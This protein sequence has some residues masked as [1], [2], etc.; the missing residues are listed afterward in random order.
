MLKTKSNKKQMPKKLLKS[1]YV[2]I[3]EEHLAK[4]GKR[5]TNLSKSTLPTLKEII[6]KYDIKFDEKSIVEENEKQKKKE[7]EEREQRDKEQKEQNRIRIE[8]MERKK[9]EWE[10]LNEEDKDKVI[11]WVVIRAQKNYLDNYWKHQK[12]NK[13][14][15]LTTDIM[16][17]KFKSE[18]AK[19]ERINNNTINVKGVNV[20]NGFYTDPFDWEKEYNRAIEDMEKNVYYEPL[21]ILKKIEEEEKSNDIF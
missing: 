6:E 16:E 15:K 9:K 1:D 13:E 12:K 5:L 17:E 3:I 4:Q 18:C 19:V 14:I 10:E 20:V 8:N 2:K 7:K 21:N 11:T